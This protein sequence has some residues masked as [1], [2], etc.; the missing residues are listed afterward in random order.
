MR[1]GLWNERNKHCIGYWMN[2]SLIYT[3]GLHVSFLG[4]CLK[5]LIFWVSVWEKARALQ[6]D[7]LIWCN[8][9]PFTELRLFSPIKLW[10]EKSITCWVHLH[11]YWRPSKLFAPGPQYSYREG[12]RVPHNSI[13][14]QVSL[15]SVF[16]VSVHQSSPPVQSNDCRRPLSYTQ[17]ILAVISS[18]S[19]ACCRL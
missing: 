15:E 5:I 10:D 1:L 16:L 18:L 14:E 17:I 3:W 6:C 2:C 9:D 4:A 7:L 11:Y 19:P 13:G 8:D 12:Y